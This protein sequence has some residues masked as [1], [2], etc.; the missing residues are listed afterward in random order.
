MRRPGKGG[1][2]GVG[3]ASGLPRAQGRMGG[4]KAPDLVT[5]KGESGGVA[6]MAACA[7]RGKSGLKAEPNRIRR[8]A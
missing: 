4:V 2:R 8:S 5:T 1:A 3:I 7:G 6:R